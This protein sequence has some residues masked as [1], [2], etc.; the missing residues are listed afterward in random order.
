LHES[1]KG[2]LR[3]IIRLL[4]DEK[5]CEEA[6]KFL[7]AHEVSHLFY[8][9]QTAFSAAVEKGRLKRKIQ[10]VMV[11]ILCGGVVR[12]IVAST[13]LGGGIGAFAGS[14]TLIVLHALHRAAVSQ[15]QEK[16]ADLKA[17]EVTGSEGGIYFYTTL[18]KHMLSFPQ[19]PTLSFLQKI[20]V[21]ILY[22]NG[23]FL[24]NQFVTHPNPR[25]RVEYLK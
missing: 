6:K 20:V 25:A 13:L 24:L 19:D 14:V 16:E 4:S 18:H 17:K 12:K 3:L 23:D 8:K 2:A 22:R 10:G 7:L 5:K 21:Q 11:G 9:H 15:G 1:D